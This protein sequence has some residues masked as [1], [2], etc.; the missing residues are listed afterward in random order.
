MAEVDSDEMRAEPGEVL[1]ERKIVPAQRDRTA[2]YG[3][4]LLLAFIATCVV[5]FFGE[6]LGIRPPPEPQATAQNLAP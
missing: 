3:W 4:I 2:P 5:V 6:K 1:V